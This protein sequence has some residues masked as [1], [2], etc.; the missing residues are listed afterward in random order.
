MSSTMK[1]TACR[2]LKTGDR[3]RLKPGAWL[4]SGWRGMGTVLFAG[5]ESVCFMKDGHTEEDG[6]THA[7]RYQVARVA[8]T[9]K[10]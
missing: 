9:A 3:V 7:M 1:R 2:E 5:G 4:M 8:S 10:A 6:K